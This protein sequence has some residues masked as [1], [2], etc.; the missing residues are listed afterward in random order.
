[1]TPDG[2]FPRTERLI[3]T[4]DFDRVYKTGRSFKGRFLILKAAPNTLL[5]NRIGFSISARSIKKAS[6]RNRL[7]R[8]FREAYRRNKAAATR[9][10]DIVLVVRQDPGKDFSY[11]EAQDV[12][13]K[14][15]KEAHI[16]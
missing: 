5:T 7:K 15:T 10:F 8:L 3:K 11:E 16:L 6:R 13:L 4:K 1:M 14:L 9:T 12:Y 2:T